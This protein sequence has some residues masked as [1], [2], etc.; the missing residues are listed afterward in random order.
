[1]E[2]IILSALLFAVGHY[3]AT[4]MVAPVTTLV[5]IRMILLNGIGAVVFGR[6]FCKKALEVS[7][8]SHAT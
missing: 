3:G 5:W 4:N 7:F 8:I 6:F 1:M 2:T